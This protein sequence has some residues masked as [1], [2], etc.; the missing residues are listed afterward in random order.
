MLDVL[1][2]RAERL[3]PAGRQVA[4]ALATAGR[5]V[6]AGLLGDLSDA[7]DDVSP[8][9]REALDHHLLVREGDVVEF[10]HVLVAEAVGRKL[11]P[12][13]R[14]ALH[15]RWAEVLRASAP[16]GVLAHHWAEAGEPRRALS[17]SITAGDL[18]AADLAAHDAFG[19]Y[20]RALQLWEQVEDPER[21]AGCSFVELSRRT[22]EVANR[23]GHRDVAVAIID[24]ARRTVDAGDDPTTASVLAE[25]RAWYLLR[26][27][28]SH[29]ADDA[30]AAAVELLPDDAPPAVRA[31]VLAGSVR[32]AEQRHDAGAA[33]VRARA[34]MDAAITAPQVQVHAHYMLARAL[35]VAQDWGGRAGVRRRRRIG[36]GAPRASHRR[37]C[38]GRPLRAAGATGPTGRGARRRHRFRRPAARRRMGRPERHARRWSG[39]EHGAAAGRRRAPRGRSPRRS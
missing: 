32:A 17:A 1:L 6:D 18:A 27:G 13:E 24:E 38:A 28:R 11:L 37:R 10:H 31:A 8:G 34:A 26:L 35:L 4:A 39:G 7:G 36:G 19:H 29:E 3:S 15:R 20:R 9:L 12:T 2:A 23:S 16:A 14:R 33:L 21:A 5:P 30:Y 25:R 22:A